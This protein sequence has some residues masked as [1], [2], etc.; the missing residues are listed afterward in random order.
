LKPPEPFTFLIDRC[1]G[2]LAVP[3][4]IRAVLEGGERVEHLDDHFPQNA[5]DD[6]W[7]PVVGQRGW[8]ILTKDS[9]LRRN[10][11]E[12][13]AMKSAETAVFI[14]ANGNAKSDQV[15][16]GLRIAL[17]RIRR[18]TRRFAVPVLGRV[19]LAGELAVIW[20]DGDE[21][22]PPKRIK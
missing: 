5:K 7:I 15:A 21:L 17:P 14:F 1:L 18:A 6:E 20:T 16:A 22:T 3:D 10:P 12:I 2:R 13:A 19:N 9:N 8:I 11:L 4:A